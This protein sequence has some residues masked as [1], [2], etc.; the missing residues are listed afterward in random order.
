MRRLAFCLFVLLFAAAGQAQTAV[1]SPDQFLG[2]PLGER[3]TPYARILDY[4]QLLAARSNLI[5]MQQFGETYEH[6]PLMLAVITSPK[7]R[8]ALDT[9]RADVAALTN[10]NATTQARANEI[11]HATPAIA[12]LAYG[13]HGNESSSAEASMEVA[14]TL[15]SDPQS[16]VLLDNLVVLIDPLENPDGR[17]RYV[18]WFIRTR[19]ADADANPDAYEHNE[20]WPGG[21]FN[22]YLV[23]MN[24]DWAWTS[25]RETIAR[26]AQYRNWNPQVFVDFHEM[27][28]QSSYFFPPDA[29]PVNANLPADVDTWLEKFG[30]ANADVFT[31]KGWPFFVGEEFDL[32]YPGYGDSWP[33][34]HGAIGMTYEV[35]GSGRGGSAIL[36]D[37]ATVYTLAD[38]IAR[39]YTTSMATLRTASENR[40]GLLLYTYEMMR[41][42]VAS[43]QNTYLLVPGSPNFRPLVEMLERQ[44]ISMSQLNAPL[45]V[46]VTRIDSDASESH[47]FPSGTVVIS[48]R[49]PLG[50]L[51]ETLLEKSPVFTKG[52]VEEQQRRAHSDEPDEFYDLTSWS[53]PLAMNV[54]AYVTA[55]PVTAEM[56]PYAASTTS[57]FHTGRYGYIIDGNDAHVYKAAGRMLRD[58]VR[59]NVSDDVVTVNDRNFARG[60]LVVLKGNNKPD[61]DTALERVAREADIAIVPVDSGWTGATSF[62]SSKIHYVKDPRIALVG[63]PRVNATSYGMLW[64]TLD[65]DTPVPHTNLSVESLRNT[66]LSKYGVIVLPDGEYADRFGKNAEK[67]KSWLNGGGT[68][69]VIKGASSFLRE[70]EAEISKLKPWEAPKKKDDDKDKTPATPELYNDYRVPGATFRTAMNGR[71]YLTFGVPSSPFVLIEGSHAFLPVSHTVDNVVTIAKEKPLVAGVAWNES[72]DR[73]K[74]SIYLVSEPYG[75][76]QVITFADEPHFRLFWRGTLPLFMNAVLYSPS[77]PRE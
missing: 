5:T 43:G 42:Q 58:S 37:D 60:S 31:K 77:F 9:I 47:I 59:F 45:T 62:G 28:Y 70:K 73:L 46:K 54:E 24:R 1:P 61:V 3:F 7:N 19:G 44:K 35:A 53:L 36:R 11:A 41:K 50:G 76:G 49:Q 69:V 32:F 15:V 72:L 67:L 66:D 26:V 25:Q 74:G 38:R 63:G 14:Y 55:G 51:A 56:H 39:H 30:R 4:F 64:H 12:W 8:A 22:H 65:I 33:A 20:P 2:Y 13:I 48:T 71:S 18:Q 75:K 52:Y 40:E 21:R 16:A 57:A 23:D 34:L 29:R 10:P 68:L 27:G 6:R 17:E